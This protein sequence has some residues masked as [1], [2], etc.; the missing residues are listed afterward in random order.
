MKRAN[1]AVQTLQQ[2]L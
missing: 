1:V 2:E